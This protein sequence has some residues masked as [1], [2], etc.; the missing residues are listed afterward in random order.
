MKRFFKNKA[1]VI[2][3]A[4]IAAV[5]ITSAVLSI[6]SEGT[7]LPYKIANA[8]VSPFQKAFTA[9][10]N[11]L[12]SFWDAQTKYDELLE[13]NEALRDEIR[14]LKQ[15]IG[16]AEMYKAENEDLHAL[17]DIRE[18]YVNMSIDTA[19]IIAWNDTSW[20]S[21]FT[22]NK[23]ARDGVT[24]ECCVITKDGL[25][26]L[27]TRVENSYSEVRS[28]I[29]T[30]FSAGAML[31][32]TNLF[33]V[34]NGHFTLMKD[35][36]LRLEY[37]PLD[38]DVKVG[39]NVATSGIGDLFPPDIVIGSVAAVGTEAGGMS[40]YAEIAPAVDIAA[41]TQ[42]FIVLGFETGDVVQ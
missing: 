1:V 14:E 16:D 37:I 19:S 36:R 7:S 24:T 38:S 39:D 30:E 4:L 40:M 29:D 28:L 9:V 22:I 34:A 26:G 2:A 17:L 8:V 33:A 6:F 31:P 27:V 12:S 18:R 5:L 23:G 42:V 15:L 20:A 32:R 3:L 25:V 35:G 41:L 13:E 21:T 10:K 11:G